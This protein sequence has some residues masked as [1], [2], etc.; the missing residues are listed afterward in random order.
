MPPTFCRSPVSVPAP[1]NVPDVKVYGEPTI[2][3]LPGPRVVVP[4]FW[5]TPAASNCIVPDRR[6]NVPAGVELG[7]EI[8]RAPAGRLLQSPEVEDGRGTAAERGDGVP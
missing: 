5:N 8:D 1:W 3:I 6:L 7:L 4:P 2:V